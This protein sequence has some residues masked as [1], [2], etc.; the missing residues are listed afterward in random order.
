MREPLHID[1]A[2]WEHVLRLARMTGLHGRLAASNDGNSDL[3]EPVRRHLV[4]A[5]R[6]AAFNARMLLGEL[7]ALA[8]LLRDVTFPVIALKG[9][10]YA[11][12][13]GMARGRFAS[14]VDLLVPKAHLRP[15]EQRLRAAGWVAAPLDA[16]DERYYRDWSHET[17]P[18]RFPGRVLEVDLHHAIT[19]VTGTLHFD[20]RPLFEASVPV[21][22]SVFRVLCPEDQ[23]LHACVH[24]FHDGDLALRVRE[25]VDIDALLRRF[26]QQED[27]PER[28]VARA[29]ELGLQRPLWYGLHFAQAWLNTPT[30]PRGFERLDSPGATSQRLMDWLVPRALLPSNP[31]FPPPTAVRLARAAMLARYHWLRMPLPMLFPH[32]ARKTALR[33]RARLV[34]PAG[35]PARKSPP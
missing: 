27:F 7:D 9:G 5:S 34:Q 18:M 24:C 10:A 8:A 1:T 32:L 16:Y 6:I 25:I 26:F 13:G 31:D 28:L 17:L 4:S 2:R 23:V 15:V 12:Q 22:D 29:Q 14:D 3:P 21:P 35:R 11:L 33:M 20:A 19:P 30:A